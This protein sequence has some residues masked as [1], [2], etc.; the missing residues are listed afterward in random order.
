MGGGGR[1]VWEREEESGEG[2]EREGRRR[3]EEGERERRRE[4]AITNISLLI[5]FFKLSFW[6]TKSRNLSR[7]T[8]SFSFVIFISSFSLPLSFFSSLFSSFSFF[9]FFS[10]FFFLSLFL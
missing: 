7:Y 3:G 1:G 2:V 4:R 8:F 5:T 6:K 10:C 9:L